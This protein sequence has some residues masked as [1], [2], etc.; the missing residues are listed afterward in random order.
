[1]V[2]IRLISS[3]L[4]LLPLLGASPGEKN[5]QLEDYL[6]EN[7]VPFTTILS[8][9]NADSL[10]AYASSLP[11]PDL[12]VRM[13][14]YFRLTALQADSASEVGL[15]KAMPQSR[16]EL[17]YLYRLTYS[18]FENKSVDSTLNSMYYSYFAVVTKA[19][20]HHRSFIQE[21][22]RFASLL[23]GESAEAFQSWPSYL[24]EKDCVWFFRSLERSH[25]QIQASIM[26]FI[27]SNKPDESCLR[28]NISR[29]PLK[30]LRAMGFGNQEEKK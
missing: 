8:I 19:V 21:Y 11:A 23:E 3:L 9:S 27:I 18:S 13:V 25:P 12:A 14:L 7:R 4:L 16:L 1:M 6:R 30:F 15:L 22:L 10:N 24:V 5:D 20:L 2:S 26:T 28:K 29:I 17:S